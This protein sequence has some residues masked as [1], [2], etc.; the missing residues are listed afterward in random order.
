[1]TWA[2]IKSQ[3]PNQLS[4]PGPL[5]PVNFKAQVFRSMGSSVLIISI[6]VLGISIIWLCRLVC[7]PIFLQHIS[8]ISLLALSFWAMGKLLGVSIACCSV[9]LEVLCG[10]PMHKGDQNGFA[11]AGGSGH[12]QP[13]NLSKL[14]RPRAWQRAVWKTSIVTFNLWKCSSVEKR[15]FLSFQL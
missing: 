13:Q 10:T 7:S 1:M 4:H 3:L 9:F 2:E 15:R 11:L 6:L 5:F 8:L 12:S 14:G